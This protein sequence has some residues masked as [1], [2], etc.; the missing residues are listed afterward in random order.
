[1]QQQ[2]VRY[3]QRIRINLPGIGDHEQ[4]G[5]VKKVSSHMCSVHLDWDKRP[6][7]VIIVYTANLDL[8]PDQP[9]TDQAAGIDMR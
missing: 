8:I 2:D 5:T 6:Q 4:V 7:H 3:G 1:M 9:S